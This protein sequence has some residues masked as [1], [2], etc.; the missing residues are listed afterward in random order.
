[1]REPIQLQPSE[2]RNR[3]LA[4]HSD[5]AGISAMARRVERHCVVASGA[6]ASVAGAADDRAW[7]QW[8]LPPRTGAFA[9]VAL[10]ILLIPGGLVAAMLFAAARRYLRSLR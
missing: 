4:A 1:M 5:R 7:Q 8:W 2:R 6:S 3:R 10:A 9:L